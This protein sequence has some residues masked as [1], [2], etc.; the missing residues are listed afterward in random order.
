MR[1]ILLCLILLSDACFVLASPPR[2]IVRG[3]D[4]G[5]AHAVNEAIIK[6]HKEGI[7][8][9]IEV[10][11][12]SPWFPEAAKMLAENRT[13]DVGVH[14][15]L[16]SEW[17]NVKWRPVSDCPSL[18]D[19]D[20]YFHPMIYPNKSYP[21][22]SLKDHDWKLEDVEKEFRAQ[23]ELAVKRLPNVSHLSGHMGC[24]AISGEVR[25]LVRRLAAEYRLDI[26]PADLGVKGIGF[27]GAR[28]TSEEKI[29]SF[30]RMLD[31]L[32]QDK[33]YLFVEHP[34]LDT[35]EMR[36]I[37]HVGYENVAVDRQGVTDAWTSPR[38]R[39]QIKARGIQLIGYRD[40]K[41]SAKE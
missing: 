13:V 34:G 29:E 23:I 10:I 16:S 39:E 31:S 12:P 11:V 38:V 40:L 37:H 41:P 4:M 14:L 27:V 8:T 26:E 32:E 36:A 18:R 19:A 21:G 17:D 22:R 15:A 35:P 7:Q 25:D 5:A 1:H 3:D 6:C 24:S 30:I 9:S 2:L 20:G 33:T 28:G